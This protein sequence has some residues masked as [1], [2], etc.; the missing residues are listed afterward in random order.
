MIEA[1]F[2]R[3]SRVLTKFPTAANP[4]WK[5]LAEASINKAVE[6]CRAYLASQDPYTQEE[7]KA[8][9]VDAF[10]LAIRSCE[11]THGLEWLKVG[12][13]KSENVL[14]RMANLP[15]IQYPLHLDT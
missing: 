5:Q 11:E 4:A 6:L 2:S 1:N 14:P 15:I 12:L 9:F 13:C 8:S 3:A 10:E 7:F